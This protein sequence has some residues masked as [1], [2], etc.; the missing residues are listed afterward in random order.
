MR[1]FRFERNGMGYDGK[2][3][4]VVFYEVGTPI[5]D[6]SRKGVGE[7]YHYSAYKIGMSYPIGTRVKVDDNLEC[8]YNVKVESG[9][10]LLKVTEIRKEEYKEGLGRK[11]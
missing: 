9:S 6:N 8:I 11:S 5:L 10:L 3:Y 2:A 1:Y 7:H 4:E